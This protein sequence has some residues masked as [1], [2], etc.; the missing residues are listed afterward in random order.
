MR[1]VG[2]YTRRPN[3]RSRATRARI[4]DAVLLQE[5]ARRLIA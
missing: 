5:S 1:S 4:N 2:P 3:A